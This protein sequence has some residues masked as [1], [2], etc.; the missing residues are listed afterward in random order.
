MQQAQKDGDAVS[1][2]LDHQSLVAATILTGIQPFWTSFW[3]FQVGL[4]DRFIRESA[5][6]RGA[7]ARLG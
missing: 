6:S 5:F 3:L 7:A 1:S 2:V 4:R